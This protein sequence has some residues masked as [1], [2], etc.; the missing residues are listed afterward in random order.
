MSGPQRLYD[1]ER[2]ER[3]IV[4]LSER[5]RG[6]SSARGLEELNNFLSVALVLGPQATLPETTRIEQFKSDVVVQDGGAGTAERL[7][8]FLGDAR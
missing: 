8:A 3:R 6:L 1:R 4:N 2:R 7:D 5:D